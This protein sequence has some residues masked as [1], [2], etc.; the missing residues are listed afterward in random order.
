MKD[1][2]IKISLLMSIIA[3]LF[4]VGYAFAQDPSGLGGDT[5]T[6]GGIAMQITTA[7]GSIGQLMIAVA[8]LAGFGFVIASIFKFKHFYKRT[9]FIFFR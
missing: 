3:V 6:I 4:Y 1:K 7:F 8:Y 9:R 5:S 2:T